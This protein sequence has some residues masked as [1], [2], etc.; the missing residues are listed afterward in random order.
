MVGK[1]SKKKSRNPQLSIVMPCLNEEETLAICIK[2]AQSSIKQNNISSEI[3][4]ADN[5]S[6][7]SS[8]QIA[9]KLG[10]RVIVQ[11][12]K[13]YGNAYRKGFAAARGEWILMADS[14]DSY[15][16]S[17]ITPFLEKLAQGYELVMGSRLRGT[18]MKGAM[19]P[20]HR[21]LGNPVLSWFL[22][23]LFKTGISD[24]HCGMRAFTKKAYLKMNLK[25][26]GMEF[27]SEMVIKSAKAKLKITEVPITL[28]PDGRSGKPHLRSFRDGWRHVRFMLMHSPKYLFF[29]PGL[30][31]IVLGALTMLAVSV[32]QSVLGHVLDTHFMLLG[33]ILSIVGFNIIFLGFFAQIT[34]LSAEFESDRNRSEK[35]AERFHLEHFLLAGF[36][37]FLAGFF[38][39]GYILFN[40]ISTD[41]GNL[42]HLVNLSIFGSTLLILGIQTIFSSFYMGILQIKSGGFS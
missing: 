27:A 7:D 9:K 28:Y 40:W 8:V 1:A 16:F 30:L 21:Y 37:G 38:I 39:D 15:D 33:S 17:H 19:P 31:I 11:K 4:V 12:H 41:F 24:S 3:I 26:T 42:D 2:K 35:L 18:I 23:L 6:T 34:T 29:L 13:G 5:G 20:L 14:D 32:R 36:F 10:A 22:N 25:T